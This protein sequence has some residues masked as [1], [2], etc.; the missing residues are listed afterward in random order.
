M[1]FM[2][3]MLL[4]F[5]LL[6]FSYNSCIDINTDIITNFLNITYD[7]D[8]YDYTIQNNKECCSNF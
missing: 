8:C 4:L 3:I 7:K 6:Q 1:N 2:L 5:A